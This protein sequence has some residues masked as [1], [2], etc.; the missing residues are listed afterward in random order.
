MATIPINDRI[1]ELWIMVRAYSCSMATNFHLWDY[2]SAREQEKLADDF[3]KL[4]PLKLWQKVRGGS[5]GQAAIA[6]CVTIGAITD[7]KGAMMLMKIG[8]LPYKPPIDDQPILQIAIENG[9]LVILDTQREVYWEK[10]LLPI[11]WHKEN[12]LW[13]FLYDLAQKAQCGLALSPGS[14]MGDSA[15]SKTM[16]TIKFRLIKSFPAELAKSIESSGRGQYKLQLLRDRIHIFSE[17]TGNVV[18]VE[19]G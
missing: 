10:N 13:C 9:G 3:D 5:N 6:L 11:D 7:N 1:Q 19:P 18:E 17:I 2:F 15:N 4:T 16:K 14:F 8:E 12:R